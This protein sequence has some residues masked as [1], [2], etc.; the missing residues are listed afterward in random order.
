MAEAMVTGRMSQE[1]K[2]QG[3][4]ILHDAGLNAS[5]AINLLFDRLIE[6]QSASFLSQSK[7]PNHDSAWKNAA[8][9]VDALSSPQKSRFD[10]MTKAEIKTERLKHRRVM[11]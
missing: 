5:Q 11:E 1:K 6:D 10:L 2:S 3:T 7:V 9:F 4:Q 8:E